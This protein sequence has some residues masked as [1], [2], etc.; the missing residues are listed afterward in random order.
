MH[1]LTS[2]ARSP[3]TQ[4]FRLEYQNLVRYASA[5]EGTTPL[6]MVSTRVSTAERAGPRSFQVQTIPNRTTISAVGASLPVACLRGTMA[7]SAVLFRSPM[8]RP[9][10]V[11]GRA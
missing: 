2:K 1:C 4:R 9:D 3:P 7:E 5:W 6:L 8:G 11:H 10:P